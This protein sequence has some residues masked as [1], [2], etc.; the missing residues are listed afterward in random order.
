MKLWMESLC[1][2]ISSRRG[3]GTDES[4]FQSTPD[5]FVAGEASLDKAK[6]KQSNQCNHY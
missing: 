3:N 5:R 4:S 6:D 2:T 1:Q